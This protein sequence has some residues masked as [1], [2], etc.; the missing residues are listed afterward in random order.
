MHRETNI[1]HERGGI[2][3]PAGC[4]SSGEN[5]KKTPVGESLL[6]LPAF[7]RFHCAREAA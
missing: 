7:S 3:L 4:Y 1:A 5:E 2:L 6:S